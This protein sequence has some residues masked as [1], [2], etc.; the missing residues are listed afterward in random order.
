[1]R[2]ALTE[3]LR[4]MLNSYDI[5]EL[6]GEALARR[7]VD[8]RRGQRSESWSGEIAALLRTR[9]NG[10]DPAERLGRRVDA[11]GL[12][13][14]ASGRVSTAR[15]VLTQRGFH[16]LDQREPGRHRSWH[17]ER[18]CPGLRPLIRPIFPPCRAVKLMAFRFGD[19]YLRLTTFI[20]LSRSP[21]IGLRA[22]GRREPRPQCAGEHA[23]PLLQQGLD[24]RSV[25]GR[26][27]VCC[28]GVSSI[29]PGGRQRLPP[30]IPAGGGPG[31]VS[32]PVS[33]FAS[34]P[35]PSTKRASR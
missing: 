7:P 2:R 31:P 29:W 34:W 33:R 24:R 12:V 21:G 17:G 4:L 1:M 11:T 13:D 22:S 3:H 10:R 26:V 23:T 15:Q 32:P 19:R 6:L 5:A 16:S 30:S 20:I 14:R 35:K 25:S 9:P 27:L 18:R 28:T 8:R